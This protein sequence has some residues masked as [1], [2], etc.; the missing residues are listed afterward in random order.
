MLDIDCSA[1]ESLVKVYEICKR[2]EVKLC[3]VRGS[4]KGFPCVAPLTERLLRLQREVAAEAGGLTIRTIHVSDSLD[5]GLRWCED[6]V[7]LEVTHSDMNLANPLEPH[8]HILT[9][10]EYQRQLHT[11]CLSESTEVVGKLFDYFEQETVRSGEVLW[12]Q[13]GTSDRAV[14]LVQGGLKSY[15]EDEEDS[16]TE[17]VGVGFLIGEYGLLTNT[18]RLSTI[19]AT[20][21]SVLF[22]LNKSKFDIMVKNDPYLAIVLSRICMVIIQIYVYIYLFLI[23]IC[24]MMNIYIALSWSSSSTCCK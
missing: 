12:R 14:L 24:H 19:V 23:N 5:D 2:F 6:G 9:K 20:A 11:L 16:T 4:R 8:P 10:P 21:D 22:V 7:I 3:Y 15:L 17:D 13:G 1:A 18:V